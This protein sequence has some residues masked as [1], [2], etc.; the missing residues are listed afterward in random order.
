[1]SHPHTDKY[2]SAEVWKEVNAKYG[3]K[4][5][6]S[7]AAPSGSGARGEI[8]YPCVVDAKTLSALTMTGDAIIR[9]PRPDRIKQWARLRARIHKQAKP[10]NDP[11]Y[12]TAKENK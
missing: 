6:G 2:G 9:D 1:M 11:S 8:N 4:T 10:L 7:L 5:D 12:A 3:P